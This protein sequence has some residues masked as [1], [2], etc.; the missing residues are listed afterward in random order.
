LMISDHSAC[1]NW[2][3]S[4]AS[5]LGAIR[6]PAQ[7]LESDRRTEVCSF[8]LRK[9]CRQKTQDS[10]DPPKM[11]ARGTVASM[12]APCATSPLGSGALFCLWNSYSARNIGTHS[13]HQQLDCTIANE[14]P[15]HRHPALFLTS[16]RVANGGETLLLAAVEPGEP[17]KSPR[18]LPCSELATHPYSHQT[19][20]ETVNV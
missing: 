4:A 10:M 8:E 2:S 9:C 16:F 5:F 18:P 14:Q 17:L 20:S 15:H 6:P 11:K 7:K 12:I 3:P 13:H 1:H 19:P